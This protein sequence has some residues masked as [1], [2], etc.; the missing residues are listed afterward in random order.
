MRLTGAALELGKEA[1]IVG[2]DAADAETLAL[3]RSALAAAGVEKVGTARALPA[4]SDGTVVVIGTT[5]SDPSARPSRALA[6]RCRISAKAMP[7]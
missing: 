5:R 7:C 1:T 2:G 6:A 3:V 4:K